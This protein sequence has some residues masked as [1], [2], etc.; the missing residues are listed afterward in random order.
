MAALLIILFKKMIQ[1]HVCGFMLLTCC[2]SLSAFPLIL[3]LKYVFHFHCNSLPSLATH[4]ICKDKLWK[5][6]WLR[7]DCHTLQSLKMSLAR[8]WH[9]LSQAVLAIFYQNNIL[10]CGRQ[11]GDYFLN[12]L[13]STKM[14]VATVPKVVTAWRVALQT[15]WLS[16]S[17]TNSGRSFHKQTAQ[18]TNDHWPAADVKGGTF[19]C[20]TFCKLSNLIGYRSERYFL[21]SPTKADSTHYMIGSQ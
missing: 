14:L 13:A 1:P 21:I 15:T 12:Q 20:P 5:T 3:T 10:N 6:N 16:I 7:A 18:N 9:V 11:L 2:L 4:A 19:Q 17:A 8:Q